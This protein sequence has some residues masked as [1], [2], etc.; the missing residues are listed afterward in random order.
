MRK[1][2]SATAFR[3]LASRSSGKAAQAVAM[4]HVVRR[5][6]LHQVF[7]APDAVAARRGGRCAWRRPAGW[8]WSGAR[9]C[10]GS[11]RCRCRSRG[12]WHRAPRRRKARPGRCRNNTH[13]RPKRPPS[14]RAPGSAG[15]GP[16]P[17]PRQRRRRRS[18]GSPARRWRWCRRG[19]VEA[20][21]ACRHEEDGAVAHRVEHHSQGRGG[22]AAGQALCPGAKA[23]SRKGVSSSCLAS[24][25]IRSSALLAGGDASSSGRAGRTLPH[26]LRAALPRMFRRWAGRRLLPARGKPAGG[27]KSLEET[28]GV[29][30]GGSSQAGSSKRGRLSFLPPAVSY[31]SMPPSWRNSVSGGVPLLLA[32][33]SRARSTVSGVTSLPPRPVTIE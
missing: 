12:C 9:R 26:R 15:H 1:P 4:R 28:V 20:G 30:R 11:P 23:V 33:N 5:D 18:C 6:D 17:P 22:A 16:S 7:A 19:A 27:P 31:S 25:C 14:P 13:H 8:R 2:S 29:W 24:L 3:T 32:T 10:S 21:T